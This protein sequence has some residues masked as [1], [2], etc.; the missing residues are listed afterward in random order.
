[1]IISFDQIL[2]ITGSRLGIVDAPCPIC[3]HLRKP[4]KQRLKVFR[5]Y[6]DVPDFARYHCAHCEARGGISAA[7]VGVPTPKT[8]AEADNIRVDVAVREAAQVKVRRIKALTLWHRRLEAD[9]GSPAHVYLRRARGYGGKIPA[10]IGFLPSGHFP[11]AMIA[12]IGMAKE[13][14]P[15]E[16][17]ISD[18]D[19]LGVH[20]TSLKSDGTG[21]AGTERDK[22]MIGKSVGAPIVLAP[23]NDGLGLAI[24]EGIEDALS[25][26]EATGL[27]AWAAGS[28][29]RLPA[30]ASAVPSYVDC[31]TIVAD[32]DDAGSS[33]SQKLADGLASHG[34]DIRLITPSNQRRA[35]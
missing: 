14:E 8:S 12:A 2:D 20:L 10:T 31:V 29:S 28:A 13:T 11:P 17:A 25:I 35:S 3:S 30:L 33:N 18:D 5:V 7:G 6:R 23:L 15:G 9:P 34:C 27:G 22:I 24:A 19:I 16:L 21:K 26:H 1:M 4:A 32:A